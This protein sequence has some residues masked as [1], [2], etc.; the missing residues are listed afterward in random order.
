MILLCFSYSYRH[1]TTGVVERVKK[2]GLP[3]VS[4]E[5][6]FLTNQNRVAVELEKIEQKR[7]AM[8]QEKS[9]QQSFLNSKK[10]EKIER[11]LRPFFICGRE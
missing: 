4:S 10:K 2:L 9:L 8:Q 5:H 7:D 11:V 6:T 3:S 1:S